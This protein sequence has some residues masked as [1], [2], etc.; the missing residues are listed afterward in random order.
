M[1]INNSILLISNIIL[2]LGALV[3]IIVA[4]VQNN[5]FIVESGYSF[6]WFVTV[7]SILISVSGYLFHSYENVRN[8]FPNLQ[9]G[10]YFMCGVA[11]VQSIFW[12]SAAA[13]MASYTKH[14]VYLKNY[15]L[16]YQSRYDVEYNS[17]FYN[18][19]CD[20]EI[21]ST[22]F[23][24]GEFVIWCIV[25]Y[26]TGLSIYK[27]LVPPPQQPQLE[28]PQSEQPQPEQPQSEQQLDNVEL[29]V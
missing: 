8:K 22:I 21:I 14:C 1:D 28:Q 18:V 27:Q 5:I 20:G 24:F 16:D 12:L 3:G 4:T 9:Y 19:K 26:T 29:N 10:I 11:F 17:N 7:V 23:G 6:Y 15:V 2:N 13:S 25:F